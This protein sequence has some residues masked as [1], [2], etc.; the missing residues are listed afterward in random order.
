MLYP[1]LQ[2]DFLMLNMPGYEILDFDSGSSETSKG[3]RSI[4]RSPPLLGALAKLNRYKNM[5][6]DELDEVLSEHG[7]KPEADYD[8]LELKY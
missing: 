4:N 6:A 3:G 5:P 1:T 8:I 2:R 7:L